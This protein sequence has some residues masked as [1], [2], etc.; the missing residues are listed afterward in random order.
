[1][2]KILISL[3]L[4]GFAISGLAQDFATAFKSIE[5]AP[6][7]HMLEGADGFG[8]GNI[9][10]LTGTDRIV[11]IDDGLEPLAPTL[12]EAAGK[13]A[14]RPI[15]FV[16]NTHVH[17]D[18]VGG[19]AALAETG[20]AIVA[21]DNIRKR[22]VADTSISGGSGGLPVITFA[23]GITFHVNGHD[24]HVFH[25]AHAHTDGDAVIHFRNTNVI[26]AGDIMFN[27]IFPFI[28][29]DNGGSVDGY[30]VGMH[31]ILAITDNSTIIIPGHGP[32]A[33]RADLERA[34]NMLIDA[35]AR[36]KA[37]VDA[38][39]S[40]QDILAADPLADYD[41]WSWDFIT[42][43]RMTGTLIRALTTAPG[44]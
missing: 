33:K 16:I 21:H 5:V 43:E 9:G 12:L 42:T 18:H 24:A 6:G 28:D 37:L 30:I 34:V 7:I 39:N 3:P 4:I 36:V 29:F 44:Q 2:R 11:L 27:G 25:V 40:E 38:G 1:M 22:L 13:L 8:G 14:G 35:K 17:G 23:D 15:D 20:A 10:L 26:H 31:K 32:V 19:N 41:D